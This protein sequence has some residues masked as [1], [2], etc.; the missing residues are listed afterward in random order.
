MLFTLDRIT[1]D[2]CRL[3]M[4]VTLTRNI[5]RVWN[6]HVSSSIRDLM[7]SNKD[8]ALRCVTI[9]QKYFDAANI[10]SAR[11]FCQKSI[12]LFE[13]P[14]ALA[15][16]ASINA[17][18]ESSTSGAAK[19][20]ATE[21]HPSA[22]GTKQRGTKPG[23]SMPNGTAG[24]LGGDKRDYTPEQHAT[25]KRVRTCR[26]TEYYEILE[27]KKDCEEADI[28]K[29]Y[30]KVRGNLVFLTNPHDDSWHWLCILTRMGHLVRTR[31]SNVCI[32]YA[33]VV[34]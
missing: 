34:P 20:S 14:Q 33:S 19:A 2:L 17:A 23:A 11:K 7:E 27:L 18:P 21:E 26:V 28:K 32:R 1:V 22:S 5:Y 31:R 9:A 25:V 4:A 3:S 30:R 6:L 12:S 16:L 10:P 15:L 13:T 29:A 8:E 24:G